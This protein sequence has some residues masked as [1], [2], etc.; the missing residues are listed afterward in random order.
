MNLVDAFDLSSIFKTF[1]L[2]LDHPNPPEVGI[3]FSPEE[4]V[5][6]NIK[7]RKCVILPLTLKNLHHNKILR[8]WKI[9]PK[10]PKAECTFIQ[11]LE[12]STKTKKL[13]KKLRFFGN[14]KVFKI[15]I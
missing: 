10:K 6:H 14:F 2:F 13:R 1:S 12:T 15:E 4:I 9:K 8:V 11:V 3:T 7:Y 5:I